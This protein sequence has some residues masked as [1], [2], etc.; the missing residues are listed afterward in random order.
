[1]VELIALTLLLIILYAVYHVG[2]YQGRIDQL[3]EEIEA[4]LNDIFANK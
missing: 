1:M 4:L 2:Y 3:T